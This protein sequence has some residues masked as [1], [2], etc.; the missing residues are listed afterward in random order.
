MGNEYLFLQAA[1]GDGLRTLTVTKMPSNGSPPLKFS[2]S[3]NGESPGD[4]F[5]RFLNDLGQLGWAVL[6]YA[7]THVPRSQA[8]SPAT[9]AR[10]ASSE[11]EAPAG[12]YLLERAAQTAAVGEAPALE[13]GSSQA[14]RRSGALE[15]AYWE[16]QQESEY[17][18]SLDKVRDV[19]GRA[20]T[21]LSDSSA[22]PDRA[23]A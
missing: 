12:A 15:H 2:R 17:V 8:N 22:P 13:A 7:P 19:L 20:H 3:A 11:F 5:I 16:A 23:S 1:W 21:R 18:V 4:G 10:S 9:W 6:T 14:D